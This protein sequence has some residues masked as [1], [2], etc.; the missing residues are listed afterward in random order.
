M[1]KSNRLGV[2]VN[3]LLAIAV[4]ALQYLT[5]IISKF[6]IPIVI[7]SLPLAYYFV[8]AMW[9]MVLDFFQ[10]RI[11]PDKQSYSVDTRNM[12]IKSRKDV[13]NSLKD[14]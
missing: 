5:L 11:L 7:L 8:Y 6:F 2:I 12:R 3:L 1:L 13:T 10:F 4:S 14:F 9:Q